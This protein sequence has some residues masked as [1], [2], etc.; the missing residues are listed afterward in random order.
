MQ[1]T[2]YLPGYHPKDLNGG[3]NSWSI[4][5]NDI[6]WNGARGFYVSLPPF[7]AEQ[8]LELVHQKEILKQT[9]LKH[10][11]IFRYQ[12]NELHRV[13]RRQ[14]EV[15]EDVRRRKL[16]ED[17]LH[18][19]TL[20]SKSFVSQLRS[21]ISQK[22][23]C[24][25]VLDLTSIEPSTLCGETFQGS[26]NSI[27]GQRVPSGADLL[28]EKNV[29]KERKISSL[30]SSASRKRMLDLELP[31]EEYMDIEDGEQFVRESSV[32]GP[33]IVIS[34]LQPQDN[35]KVNFANPGDPSISNSS[36][37]GSF[38]LF[39]LNEPI[40][41]DETGYPNSALESVN[42]HE[43]I[44]N[45]D[46]DLSGTVH[47]ECS[48]LKKEVTGGDISNMNSSDEVSSVEMTLPQC[49][50]TA[51]SSRGFVD[52]SH[53][54]T[55]TD[56]SL[57]V[58]SRKKMKE[59]PFAVQALPCFITNSSLSKSPNASVGNSSL[60]G[61]KSDL[62]NSSASSPTSGTSGS[63]LM[64]YGD[65]EST[66]GKP[67]AVKL[68]NIPGSMSSMKRMDLNCTPSA[69]L[70]DNQFTTHTSNISHLN[71]PEGVEREI[72]GT[73]LLDCILSPDSAV[74]SGKS[75]R[76]SHSVGPGS[77]SKFLTTNSCINMSCIKDET[78]SPGH[79][80]ATM[81]TV[82]RDLEEPTSPETKECSPPIG[83]SLDKTIGKSVQWSKIDHMNDGAGKTDRAAAEILLFISSSRGNSKIAKGG[84]SEASHDTLGWLADIATSLASN[85]EKEVG[86]FM[87]L[88]CHCNTL[89]SDRSNC[90]EVV[91]LTRKGGKEKEAVCN[92]L[93]S[94]SRRSQPRRANYQRVLQTEVHPAAASVYLHQLNGGLESPASAALELGPSR[95]TP[96][97]A[98][99]RSRR[100]SPI[101][102]RTTCSLLQPQP[103]NDKQVISERDWKGWGLTK[104][105]Q[106]SRRPR[107]IFSFS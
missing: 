62:Y 23:H 89:I 54:G 37:R 16:V 17:H 39:D 92:T 81:T 45:M 42:I 40:Q 31:A 1:C 76:D 25:M 22:S 11:A 15:M 41:L 107:S 10:E 101:A 19:Q 29:T 57:L 35:S 67:D 61:K 28:A 24:Q 98:S 34:E 86:E 75:S 9:I 46:Q 85:P 82:D 2:S 66:S 4:Q 30:K 77:V 7:M 3:G 104:E 43:E 102:I 90:N 21:E 83:D 72:C 55:R 80:E 58:S 38:L 50:Q 73:V 87:N 71:L 12:V 79:S 69:D 60:T 5:H 97:R 99:S 32:Q 94:R 27:A 8:N 65:N 106:N 100:W 14:R 13:H 53:N 48:T 36:P 68:S 78:F 74:E 103:S 26:S 95:K 91:K 47:A 93:H 96:R 6:P 33:N 18:L 52:K 59:I 70:S 20:E 84:P 105:R 51:S 49:N 63:Y 64:K 56:K 88:H 44:S